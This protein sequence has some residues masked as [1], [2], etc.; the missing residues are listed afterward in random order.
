M[1]EVHGFLWEF[2]SQTLASDWDAVVAALPAV[3][4]YSPGQSPSKKHP[5]PGA[6]EAVQGNCQEGKE[7][8]SRL[9]VWRCCAPSFLHS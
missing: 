4:S 7:C 9:Q 6:Q 1:A 8:V 5:E 2:Y 3:H